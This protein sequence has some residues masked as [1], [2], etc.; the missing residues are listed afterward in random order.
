MKHPFF[1]NYGP[2]KINELLKLSGL[3]DIN[4]LKNIKI[5]DIK[6]LKNST[7]KDITFFH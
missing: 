4:N 6:D 7:N 1:K 3:K 5:Y 2:F